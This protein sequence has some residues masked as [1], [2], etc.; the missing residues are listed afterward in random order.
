MTVTLHTGKPTCSWSRAWLRECEARH[1][2][3]MGGG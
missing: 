2:L 3:S 1:V